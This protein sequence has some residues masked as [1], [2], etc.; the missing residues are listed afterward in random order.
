MHNNRINDLHEVEGLA[1]CPLLLRLT[2]FGNPC[3]LRGS[4]LDYR[5]SVARRIPQLKALDHHV[6]AAKEAAEHDA[7][8]IVLASVVG[9]DR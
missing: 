9:G 4:Q 5:K 3:S 2:L 7:R 8:D 6:V 1:A